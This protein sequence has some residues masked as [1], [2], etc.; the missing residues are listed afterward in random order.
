MFTPRYL[1]VIGMEG[2]NV[3]VA[4]PRSGLRRLSAQAFN[5][6]WFGHLTILVPKN[7]EPEA[8]LGH[9]S[10]GQEVRSLQFRL[11]KLGF[12]EAEPGGVYDAYTIERVKDFQRQNRI[13]IDGLVGLET[14][15]VLFSQLA[16]VDAP[17]L[18]A[19]HAKSN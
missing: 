6:Q 15:L 14:N 4:D 9:R 18:L 1:A 12:F 13:K 19:L 11:K 3:V 2:D 17:R 8:I 10:L 5:E 7:V 16:G